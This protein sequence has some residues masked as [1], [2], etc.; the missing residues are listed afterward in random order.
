MADLLSSTLKTIMQNVSKVVVDEIKA[1][2]DAG[3]YPTGNDPDRPNYTSIQNSIVVGEPQPTTGGVE[4]TI[5]I[6]GAKAPYAPAFEYGSG[7]HATRG[8]AKK[9]IIHA[10]D[11]LLRF[12]FTL[13][14]MPGGGKFV[15]MSGYGRNRLYKE[16]MGGDNGSVSGITFWNFVEHPGI[17]PKPFIHPSLIKAQDKIA[18][19]IK[20]KLTAQIILGGKIAEEIK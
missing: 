2:L 3:R 5:T 11:K 17:E 7:L 15:G 13:T 18:K 6:G 4:V 19:T 9:Y 8:A 12:P 20:E 16:L 14:F 1:T 10:K